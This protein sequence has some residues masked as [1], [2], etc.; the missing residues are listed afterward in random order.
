MF[1]LSEVIEV[2][3]T[4][5]FLLVN[6]RWIQFVIELKLVLQ[7][8]FCLLIVLWQRIAIRRVVDAKSICLKLFVSNVEFIFLC[9]HLN[10]LQQ[11]RRKVAKFVEAQCFPGE[12]VNLAAHFRIRW[13]RRCGWDSFF[14]LKK[15]DFEI[16]KGPN[17]LL[18]GQKMS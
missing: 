15:I 3:L 9:L 4:H 7:E 8:R 14:R 5:I 16:R 10:S 11:L 13:V 1:V 2:H 18:G 17:S 6:L 12:I